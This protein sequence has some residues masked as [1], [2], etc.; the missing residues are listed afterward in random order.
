MQTQAGWG[1]PPASC[2]TP[3][4]VLRGVLYQWHLLLHPFLFL[5]RHPSPQ[6]LPLSPLIYLL[7]PGALEL[8]M[9]LQ[10]PCEYGHTHCVQREV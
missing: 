3:F 2:C 5:P 8:H 6:G 10:G 4:P 7:S 9:N 1:V